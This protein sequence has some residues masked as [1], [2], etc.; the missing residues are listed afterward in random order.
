[1][2]WIGGGG[3]CLESWFCFL[4]GINEYNV[5]ESYGIVFCKYCFWVEDKFDEGYCVGYYYDL[6]DGFEEFFWSG[7]FFG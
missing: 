2:F 3:I 1:M 4:K 7:V 6:Y 5:C